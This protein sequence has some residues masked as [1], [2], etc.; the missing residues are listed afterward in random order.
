MKLMQTRKEI[1]YVDF[2][3]GSTYIT[4]LDEQQCECHG[5]AVTLPRQRLL[6]FI[7][8]AQVLGL[9]AGKL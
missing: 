2:G 8:T 5:K 7:A 3:Q 6:D 4:A 9:K 1:Y